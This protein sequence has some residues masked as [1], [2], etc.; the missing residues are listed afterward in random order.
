V[1][2]ERDVVEGDKQ[3]EFASLKRPSRIVN[4]SRATDQTRRDSEA[5]TL[6]GESGNAA[7]NTA[8]E[9]SWTVRGLLEKYPTFF[10]YANT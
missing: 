2:T 10:L 9:E 1:N 8:V 3:V 6:E 4:E 5:I 7:W